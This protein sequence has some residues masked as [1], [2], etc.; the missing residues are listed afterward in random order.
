MIAFTTSDL[1]D[2]QMQEIQTQF[3]TFLEDLFFPKEFI[4]LSFMPLMSSGKTDRKQLSN[5]ANSKK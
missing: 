3:I 2:K 4:K 1:D 5:M